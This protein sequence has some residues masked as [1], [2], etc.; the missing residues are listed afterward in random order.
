MAV[1]I[2]CSGAWNTVRFLKRRKRHISENRAKCFWFQRVFG[3]AL[4]VA[5]L[6]TRN[7]S[8]L[9][10]RNTFGYSQRFWLLATRCEWPNWRSRA[11]LRTPKTSTFW[12]VTNPKYMSEVAG[13]LSYA[14]V[15]SGDAEAK[16]RPPLH[17]VETL[18]ISGQNG[19][20][21]PFRAHLAEKSARSGH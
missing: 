10:T 4:P 15:W 12:L 2:V 1:S 9:A 7:A 21:E 3:K 6:A 11:T 8:D 17:F 18:T 5:N 19:G 20:D 14:V 13:N 16:M